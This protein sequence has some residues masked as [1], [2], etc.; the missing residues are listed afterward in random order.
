MSIA[1]QFAKKLIE[2]SGLEVHRRSGGLFGV[3]PAPQWK[4]EKSPWT[5]GYETAKDRLITKTLAD[6]ALVSS[7]RA[8]SELPKGHGI[9]IDERCVEYPW[10]LSRLEIGAQ[11]ILDAGSVLNHEIL[12]DSPLLRDRALHILTL[13]PESNCFWSR[14]IS[15]IYASLL[16]IP[17][18][19]DYYDAVVCLSTLEHVGFDNFVFTGSHEPARPD[20]FLLAM[21]EVR[22][23]LKP[24]GV[25]LLSVPFGARQDFGAF[26]QFDLGLV[27]AAI[28]AFA[29][30][31][32]VRQRF[33]RYTVD[34]WN[35]STAAACGDSRYV[36]WVA[37]AWQ[38][39]PWPEPRRVESDFAAAARAVACVE[40]VKG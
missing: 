7:F 15:Y 19:N 23:V 24:G 27:T 36:D 33:Y 38:G 40:F 37:E 9:G 26:R 31:R 8:G 32:E 28:D 35:L 39:K 5:P 3:A 29:P 30:A 34:G 16:D 12:V 20:E 25:L 18:R 10:A 1:R 21:R 14:G 13:A 11:R 22:R 6:P 4:P 2:R 17:T